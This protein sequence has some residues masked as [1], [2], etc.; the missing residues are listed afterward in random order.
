MLQVASGSPLDVY[1][2][3][4]KD[5]YVLDFGEKQ[6]LSVRPSTDIDMNMSDALPPVRDR[7]FVFNSPCS[8]RN[9]TRDE[10]CAESNDM[11]D[12]SCEIGYLPRE[13]Y[14]RTIALYRF[15]VISARDASDPFFSCS[16]G[17]T[18]A[19]SP[20]KNAPNS[21]TITMISVRVKPRRDLLYICVRT[22]S[23]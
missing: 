19:R 20:T 4:D 17:S 5:L 10:P 11:P 9:A 13:A 2:D 23:V 6:T 18:V 8:V 15:C 14:D 21:A 7:K 1:P 12:M 16:N 3:C 22:D